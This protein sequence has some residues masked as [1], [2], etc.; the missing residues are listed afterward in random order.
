MLIVD[1]GQMF[2]DDTEPGIDVILPDFTYLREQAG[3]ID[4]CLLTHAHDIE[5]R[6]DGFV[7]RPQRIREH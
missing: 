6:G 5:F 2:P 7:V 4:G 3:R 1:C